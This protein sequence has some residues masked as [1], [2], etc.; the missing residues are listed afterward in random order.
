MQLWRTLPASVS[1]HSAKPAAHGGFTGTVVQED[2]GEARHD[3]DRKTFSVQ[4]AFSGSRTQVG[5][6]AGFSGVWEAV[7]K[8]PLLNK[9][10]RWNAIPK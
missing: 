9:S 7:G 2:P 8:V 1:G 6:V 3:G 4:F 10:K 5:S